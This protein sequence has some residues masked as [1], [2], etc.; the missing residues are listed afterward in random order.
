MSLKIFAF[1]AI[2]CLFIP[3]IQA[4]T[5]AEL[6]P[7]DEQ[8]A[9]NCNSFP[10]NATREQ[11]VE[12]FIQMTNVVMYLHPKV[13][14]LADSAALRQAADSYTLLCTD[15]MSLE[16][17]HQYVRNWLA[18]I[19]CGHTTSA[20][21]LDWYTYQKEAKQIIPLDVFIS[22][23]KL[24][25]RAVADST[26]TLQAGMEILT[27]N[28]IPAS[29]ILRDMRGIQTNDGINKT[30]T[31]FYVES[32][33]RTYLLFLYG[34]CSQYDIQCKGPDGNI[35]KQAILGGLKVTPLKLNPLPGTDTIQTVD[36]IANLLYLKEKPTTAI[37][38]IHSFGF[39][40]YKRFYKDVFKTNEQDSIQ[41]LIIDIRGNGGG[42][43][44]NGNRLLTYLLADDFYFYISNPKKE[45]LK[46]DN[47][48][49]NFVSKMTMVL[50]NTIP[51]RDK[52][53]PDK[54]T[55][56]PYSVKKKNHYDG[57]IYC[58]TDGG[59][60]SMSSYV[61]AMLNE[62]TQAT[63]V[64]TETGGG[65]TGSQAALS[66]TYTMPLSGI[67]IFIPTHKVDHKVQNALPNRGVMPD[68]PLS[69]NI[70]DFING[71]DNVLRSLVD[72]IPD[73][74]MEK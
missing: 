71:D 26:Q 18:G 56:V 67:R 55:W 57:Q 41:H 10:L 22:Q 32:L 64:G 9:H 63:I 24:W 47:L 66:Y 25:I 52:A 36:G 5:P 70:T 53:D 72:T 8:S 1:Q 3:C 17:Y 4:Q 74:H 48:S 19:G 68:T 45:K 61:A 31:D 38:S 50:F 37:L 28:D 12:E 46:D 16:Q 15:S 35:V 11:L 62:H 54:N 60:F 2:L 51:D 59:T 23:N 20:P 34:N 44:P 65:A 14:I 43:F 33:F 69:R 73:E 6:Q 27:I 39:P 42:Y 30:G 21:S 29:E 49:M 40:D 13:T 58:M 7:V